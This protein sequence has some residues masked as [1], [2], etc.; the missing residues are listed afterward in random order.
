MTWTEVVALSVAWVLTM[1]MLLA[2][3][4]MS[5]AWLV[6]LPV[7]GLLYMGGWLQ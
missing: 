4:G 5:L 7:V 1:A 3:V 2:V 6:I